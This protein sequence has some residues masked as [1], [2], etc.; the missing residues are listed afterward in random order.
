MSPTTTATALPS[1]A[2]LIPVS[3]TPHLRLIGA[4]ASGY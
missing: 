4:R 3:P 2:P 1:P